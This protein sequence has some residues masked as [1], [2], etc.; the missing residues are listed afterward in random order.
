MISTYFSFSPQTDE[1]ECFRDYIKS[2]TGDSQV[3]INCIREAKQVESRTRDH[4][5]FGSNYE[6]FQSWIM[7]FETL[8][9]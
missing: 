7:I 9:D 1:S 2:S 8:T 6:I 5:S 3:E 4:K